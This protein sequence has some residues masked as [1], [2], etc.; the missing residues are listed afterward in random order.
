MSKTK[1]SMFINQLSS[2]SDELTQM[3]PEDIDIATAKNSIELL[4]KTNPRVLFEMFDTYI[5]P[6]RQKILD[7]DESFFLEN[8]F[9]N[10][11]GSEESYVQT[12][13]NLKKCWT[14]MSDESKENM[15]LYFGVLIKLGDQVRNK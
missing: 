11:T 5:Q 10:E 13:T 12:M 1:L 14:S 2:L 9:N 8:S 6:Y 15:W 4:K 7:R 3:Y